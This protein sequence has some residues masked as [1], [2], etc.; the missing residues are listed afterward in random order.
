MP[1]GALVY[2][3]FQEEL[4]IENCTITDLMFM[5]GQLLLMRLKYTV[6]ICN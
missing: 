3:F 4:I 5:K 1:F 2:A 6:E